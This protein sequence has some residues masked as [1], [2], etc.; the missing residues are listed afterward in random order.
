MKIHAGRVF[1]APNDPGIALLTDDK[2]Y[3]AHANLKA[4]ANMYAAP[5]DAAITNGK[6]KLPRRVLKPEVHKGT[7]IDGPVDYLYHDD[8]ASA[9]SAANYED[10]DAHDVEDVDDDD[11]DNVNIG[12]IDF[13]G[14]DIFVAAGYGQE[15]VSSPVTANAEPT[16]TADDTPGNTVVETVMRTPIKPDMPKLTGDANMD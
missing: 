14:M 16:P 10:D 5:L 8:H 7:F 2:W 3:D 1:L 4:D 9:A 12:D 11:H 13:D 6:V 15:P